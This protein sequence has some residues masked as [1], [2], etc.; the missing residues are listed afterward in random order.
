MIFF[1]YLHFYCPSL[2][3]SVKVWI[4]YKAVNK[5][6]GKLEVEMRRRRRRRKLKSIMT[7]AV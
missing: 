5:M 1:Q 4:A 7:Q 3:P 2:L 6:E